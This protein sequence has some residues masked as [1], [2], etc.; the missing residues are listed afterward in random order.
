MAAYVLWLHRRGQDALPVRPP[1]RLQQDHSRPENRHRCG[2]QPCQVPRRRNRRYHRRPAAHVRQELQHSGCVRIRQL[3]RLRREPDPD[4]GCQAERRG[5]RWP[6]L[7]HHRPEEPEQD[8]PLHR[9]GQLPAVDARSV[10]PAGER[11]LQGQ[12]ELRLRRDRGDLPQHRHRPAD[13]RS[14]QVGL[15]LPLHRGARFR[16]R[17]NRAV[18]RQY[19]PRQLRRCILP[20][21]RHKGGPTVR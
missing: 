18:Q 6:V 16:S 2:R 13:H 7:R 1:A 9:A 4:H 5:G 19:R 12:Q 15:P 11:R 17:G 10:H 21:R 14:G 20:C 8:L 3:L